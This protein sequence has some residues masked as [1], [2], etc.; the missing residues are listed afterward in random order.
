MTVSED[1]LVMKYKLINGPYLFGQRQV[2]LDM[3]LGDVEGLNVTNIR[4]AAVVDR[5]VNKKVI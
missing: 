4:S 2:K 3:V 1:G 5:L